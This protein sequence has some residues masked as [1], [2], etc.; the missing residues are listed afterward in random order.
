MTTP[1]PPPP[2]WGNRE[3]GVGFFFALLVWGWGWGRALSDH[4]LKL[5]SWGLLD[6]SWQALTCKSG[7][8]FP[9]WYWQWTTF[10][11]FHINYKTHRSFW[12]RVCS[13]LGFSQLISFRTASFDFF[14]FLI[15]KARFSF[16]VSQ[17]AQVFHLH[18]WVWTFFHKKG[19]HH[20]Q[21][22]QHCAYFCS[23]R[24]S[25]EILQCHF[26]PP[27]LLLD[28]SPGQMHALRSQDGG[29]CGLLA[30]ERPPSP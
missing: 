23:S 22:M 8:Y 14:F 1:P 21:R 26:C 3:F 25:R 2:S 20:W 5:L 6:L 18:H 17:Q 30:S 16:F 15:G 19:R 12:K 4:H 27:C 28:S 9:Q 11:W 10:W 7:T 13:R 29:C 24:V